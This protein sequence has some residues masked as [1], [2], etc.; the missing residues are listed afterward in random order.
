MPSV[1]EFLFGSDYRP[2]PG[3]ARIEG[4]RRLERDLYRAGGTGADQAGALDVLA[5]DLREVGS[6]E[7]AG[8]GELAARRQAAIDAAAIRSRGASA[9]GFGAGGG[10]LEVGRQ[11]ATQGAQST[12]LA[13]EAAISDQERARQLEA[14]IRAGLQAQQLAALGGIGGL[15][16]AEQA[17]RLA[18]EGHRAGYAGQRPG[19]IAGALPVAGAVLA[20]R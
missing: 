17:G 6:G 15:R 19:L 9:R 1:G 11:L 20:G 3:A 12:A 14:Q 10:G 18:L 4:R 8:A 16:Q 5:G 7:A 13:S 2:D